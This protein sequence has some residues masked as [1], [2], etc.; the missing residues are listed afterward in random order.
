MRSPSSERN[1]LRASGGTPF[2]RLPFPR[3]LLLLAIKFSKDSWI[4]RRWLVQV[5]QAPHKASNVIAFFI[6][7]CDLLLWLATDQVLI[8]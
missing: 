3:P 4:F 8:L 1:V 5:C 6:I 7:S 2:R